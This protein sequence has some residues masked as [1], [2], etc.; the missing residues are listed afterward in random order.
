[1][2]LREATDLK[3]IVV[4][5]LHIV[6]SRLNL[7]R[8]ARRVA[9]KI[10]CDAW[11]DNTTSQVAFVFTFACLKVALCCSLRSVG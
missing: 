8:D 5:K 4:E 10:K 6:L 11:I 1:M 7:W 9:L 3:D 2:I